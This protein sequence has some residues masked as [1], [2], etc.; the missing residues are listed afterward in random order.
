MSR[1]TNKSGASGSPRGAP[2]QRH[3]TDP[4]EVW[5][6]SET[7][8]PE[9]TERLDTPH[10]VPAEELAAITLLCGWFLDRLG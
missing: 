5:R 6:S 1:A 10:V 2:R 8:P 4:T 9:T 3:L 7:T